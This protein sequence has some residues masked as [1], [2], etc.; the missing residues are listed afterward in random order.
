MTIVVNP[1]LVPTPPPAPLAPPVPAVSLGGGDLGTPAR[2]GDLLTD[3]L[4]PS[5][6]PLEFLG[7]D[8]S[9]QSPGSARGQSAADIFDQDGL[10]QGAV[11]GVNL[12]A[13]AIIETLQ[14][15]P[16]G[17]A[18]PVAMMTIPAGIAPAPVSASGTAQPIIGDVAD[19]VAVADL[20]RTFAATIAPVFRVGTVSAPN[21]TIV[22]GEAQPVVPEQVGGS[23]LLPAPSPRAR[24]WN[25]ATRFLAQDGA[26]LS[27]QVSVQAIE[28]GLQ[29]ATRVG[30]LDREERGRLRDRI[31]ALLARNGL[32]GRNVLVNGDNSQPAVSAMGDI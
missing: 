9:Y 21:A 8:A 6:A 32:T 29:V 23:E 16:K 11:A 7:D 13:P 31:V 27:T 5:A 25:V 26:T 10:F 14:P 30:S 4:S 20:K 18:A 2:F 3:I 17:N 24:L 22:A 1:F 28:H 15:V 12:A 19:L